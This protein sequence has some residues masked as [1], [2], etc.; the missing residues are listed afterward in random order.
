MGNQC[1]KAIEAIQINAFKRSYNESSSETT[2][3]S[4]IDKSS[5]PSESLQGNYQTRESVTPQWARNNSNP[6][7]DNNATSY[8]ASPSNS[9]STSYNLNTNTNSNS[10]S[11]SNSNT[12]IMNS[13]TSM[14]TSSQCNEDTIYRTSM[15]DNTQMYGFSDSEM[16]SSDAGIRPSMPQFNPPAP[17]LSSL[18]PQFS[19]SMS[20]VCPPPPPLPTLRPQF[21]ISPLASSTSNP[22]DDDNDDNIE[23][24]RVSNP[25][26]NEIDSD[27]EDYPIEESNND[28]RPSYMSKIFGNAKESQLNAEF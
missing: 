4:N 21:S 25:N 20:Q 24:Q 16:R 8:G 6:M 17:P 9:L 28:I 12:G 7:R 27:N 14:N 23:A 2:R 15:T 5:R 1:I 13:S 11:N 10:N 3:K 18:S 22:F 26:K 19:T